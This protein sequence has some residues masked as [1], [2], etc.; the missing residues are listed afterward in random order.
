MTSPRNEDPRSDD[1]A[2]ATPIYYGPPRHSRRQALA[3]ELHKRTI[4][5]AFP[6]RRGVD[7]WYRSQRWDA[8]HA[9][10]GRFV[11]AQRHFVPRL[12]NYGVFLR[13]R[14]R[15]AEVHYLPPTL[16]IET[17][18]RC[19]LRCP[20]CLVGDANAAG[21]AQS[22]VRMTTLE[23]F[24]ASIDQTYRRCVQV[25]FFTHGEPLL[26]DDVF[27]ACEYARRKGLWTFMHS[28]LMPKVSDLAERLIASGLCNLVVS[29]DGATQDTYGTYRRG[30]QLE[31]I[32]AKVAAIAEEKRRRRAIYPWITAKFIVF[33]H[34][35]HEIETFKARVLKA[36]AD[37]ALFVSGFANHITGRVGA[38]RE[39]DLDTL[40]WRQR[41]FPEKCPFLW[42]DLRLGSDGGLFS[43]GGGH[44]EEDLFD[45]GTGG[46]DMVQRYNSPKHVRMRLYFLGQTSRSSVDVPKPCDNCELVD[47]FQSPERVGT[48]A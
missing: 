20:G 3:G 28:N 42:S 9:L 15:C 22:A 16:V 7:R 36:G 30:G 38:D 27:A 35:W 43:C 45:K 19:Q 4:H 47:R 32:L 33:E 37:E 18:M 6:K 48:H 24:R 34:N 29:I 17:G 11:T 41:N 39:F 1:R 2:D 12:M 46:A 44:R 21:R 13:E 8:F 23:T 10:K 14:L 26:N 31:S 40:E 5:M 25:A